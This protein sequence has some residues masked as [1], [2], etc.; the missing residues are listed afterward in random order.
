[1]SCHHSLWPTPRYIGVSHTSQTMY[2][3]RIALVNRM[4]SVSHRRI[5]D[6]R[7][8]TRSAIHGWTSNTSTTQLSIHMD[9]CCDMSPG[10]VRAVHS[11]AC[12]M[13]V[14]LTLFSLCVSGPNTVLCTTL[15]IPNSTQYSIFAI[16]SM[17]TRDDRSLPRMRVG[18]CAW[19]GSVGRVCEMMSVRERREREV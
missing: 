13:P 11:C 7:G 18:V 16:T 17:D 1:M 6:E 9:T 14:V 4:D 8:G 3:T 5:R 10:H 12:G 19:G 2:S 15:V